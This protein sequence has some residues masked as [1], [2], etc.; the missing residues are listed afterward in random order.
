MVSRVGA[1]TGVL[2][3]VLGMP[4]LLVR[5]VGWPLPQ[6]W[7]DRQRWQLWLAQ[8]LTEGS[9]TAA[10]AVVA[11]LI[12]LVLVYALLAEIMLRL[13]ATVRW[14]VRL[15]RLPLPTP[16]Q[17]LAGGMLG[18]VAVTAPATPAAAAADAS[19]LDGAA[20]RG[21]AVD[22]PVAKA[23]VGVA[24]PDGGW[25]PHPLACL[26]DAAAAVVWSRRRRH[27]RPG[28]PAGA[29]REDPDLASLPGTVA[30]VLAALHDDTGSGS[31]VAT[32]EQ[33][34]EQLIEI[35][36]LPAGGVGLSGPGAA[37]AARGA[38]LTLVLTHPPELR[39]PRVL[40][41]SSHVQALLGAAAGGY[42]DL[43]GLHIAES[44][45][46]AVAD[47]ERMLLDPDRGSDPVTVLA[48]APAEPDLA[49]RVAVLLTLGAPHGVRGLILGRWPFGPTW[50]V[51]GDGATATGRRL[52]T[53]TAGAATDL[54]AVAAL[55]IQ[56]TPATPTGRAT[57]ATP[58]QRRPEPVA[59]ADAAAPDRHTG[60]GVRLRLLGRLALTRHGQPV[61]MPRSA[62]GQ[63]LAFLALH[64]D[65]ASSQQL[66]AA[67]W[68]H[69]RWH[70]AAARCYTAVSVLRTALRAAAGGH[71]VLVRTGERYT[72]DH[73]LI[74]VDVVRLL[75][76]VQQAATAL[77]PAERDAALHTVVDRYT[78]ELIAGQRWPWLAPHREA[79]R[80]HVIDAYASLA[81][82]H[83]EQA[84]NLLQQ[85]V[86]VDPVNEHLH[87]QALAALAAVGDHTK[88]TAAQAPR[89]SPG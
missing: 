65:G 13:R 36:E 32:V 18:A 72:L 78:G 87:R 40:T 30:A 14:L 25:L 68:P 84:V 71:D 33:A 75:H 35:G 5:W 54:L 62:A 58:P 80:R 70:A 41:T 83:P 55:R 17:G 66:A 79:I 31:A 88:A 51:T 89:S 6:Q 74:D 64:Q 1:V 21:M 48:A 34:D 7:P 81:A 52:C 50:H 44:L 43:P 12:W 46:D 85:A 49:R 4:V 28:P 45:P 10:V 26:V 11:W 37:A 9:I 29:H 2:T 15:P 69:L 53:L 38:L 61:R 42:G 27:Y 57:P 86:R 3:L 16:M 56:E 22:R 67:V 8:P 47:L 82:S 39:R 76:A 23:S 63:V 73:T 19:T 59:A 20:T 24:L 60:T 77:Q